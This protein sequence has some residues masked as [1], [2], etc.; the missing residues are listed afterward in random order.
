MNKQQMSVKEIASKMNCSDAEAYGFVKFLVSQ[1]LAS[2]SG[3][4]AQS[5][6]RGKP[7]SLYSLSDDAQTILASKI[8]MI[9]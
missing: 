8:Q 6:G 4:R 3:K 5:S 1:K 7:T 2:V 9:F